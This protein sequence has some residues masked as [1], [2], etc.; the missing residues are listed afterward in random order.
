M[1]AA[2]L[3]L[4]YSSY[5]VGSLRADLLSIAHL[6]IGTRELLNHFVGSGKERFRNR[7]A[8]RLGSP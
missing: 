5:N 6:E 3:A 7:K 1:T 4:S 8:E 2:R